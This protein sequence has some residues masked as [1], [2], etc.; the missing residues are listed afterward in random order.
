VDPGY[1]RPT[2]VETL[3][4]DPAKA[5]EQLGWVPE[6]SFQDMVQEMVQND[7]TLAQR[8]KLCND[9]GYEVCQFHE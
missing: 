8:D 3:L 6:I 7:Y 4:G 5:R 9:H 2:E 1:F